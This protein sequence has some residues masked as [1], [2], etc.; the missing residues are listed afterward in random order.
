MPRT[1]QSHHLEQRHPA[2]GQVRLHECGSLLVLAHGAAGDPAAATVDQHQSPSAARQAA[3]Q[4]LTELRRTG[5]HVL[6]RLRHTVPA[7]Q[8]AQAAHDPAVL[9]ASFDE[10]WAASWQPAL[11]DLARAQRSDTGTITHAVLLR[12]WLRHT[13]GHPWG[14]PLRATLRRAPQ[15]LHEPTGTLLVG[16]GPAVAEWLHR[17]YVPVLEREP[18]TLPGHSRDTNLTYTFA[19]GLWQPECDGPL[20]QL[21]AALE[22]S[23]DLSKDD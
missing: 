14:G 22:T 6:A 16:V 20:T 12:S 1:V 8:A 7:A 5:F 23:R 4:Y 19:F 18:A 13:T 3:Q 10:A 15:A 11:A 9:D 17:Y 21:Q 2:A